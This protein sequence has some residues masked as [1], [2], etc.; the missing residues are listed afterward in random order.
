MATKKE[1][2]REILKD[3]DSLIS[4][5]EK[6]N[7]EIRSGSTIV[8]KENMPVLARVICGGEGELK[9][10]DMTNRDKYTKYFKDNKNIAPALTLVN[11]AIQGADICAI[12]SGVGAA[13]AFT[14]IGATGL[15]TLGISTASGM[16]LA[17]LGATGMIPA[18][19]PIGISLLA[20]SAGSLF[21]KSKKAKENRDRTEKLNSIFSDCQSGA[22]SCTEK[23]KKN[24]KK[25][26]DIISKKL[27]ESVD[28]LKNTSKKIAINIDDALHADQNLRIMQYQEIVLKQY[29][30]Q[31][32]IRKMLAELIE[33]YNKLVAENE[34]LAR[35]VASYE[36]NMRMCGCTNNY[37][38]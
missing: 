5:L 25:I 31:N 11:P 22:Q 19:W 21:I 2:E 37:F 7:K 20:I 26:K 23:I 33:A 15:G 28:A 18:L 8:V 30:S 3:V 9:N 17:G 24:N 32:E 29:N 1:R 38:A 13:G 6:R 35:Q 4:W 12:A 14:S 34:Q 16:S 36:A 27:Q 10:L